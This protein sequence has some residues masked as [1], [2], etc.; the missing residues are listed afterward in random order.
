MPK[1]SKYCTFFHN[2]LC[3]VCKT[4][5]EQLKICGNCKTLAYCSKEHQKHDWK[6]HKDICKVISSTDNDFSDFPVKTYEDFQTIRYIRCTAWQN[7]LNR[8]LENFENQMWM[9]PR[10]CAVCYSKDVKIDCRNCISVLYCSSEHQS[11][12]EDMHR[13]Y[14]DLLKLSIDFDIYQILN[15]IKLKAVTICDIPDDIIT[16][17]NNLF[18]LMNLYI[19]NLLEHEVEDRIKTI[20]ICDYG[21]PAANILFCLEQSGLLNGR[22]L[23]KKT[24]TIHLVGA[25]IVEIS[26]DWTIVFDMLFHWIRNLESLNFTLVGPELD[27]SL[28]TKNVGNDMCLNCK[29]NKVK[30]TCTFYSKMYHEVVNDLDKPDL[31]VA[32]NSGL[33]A[34]DENSWGESI[35]LLTKN[36]EV[37]LLLTAYTSKELQ[38]DVDI[39][40]KNSSPNL[41][42]IVEPQRNPFSC[43]RPMRDFNTLNVPIFYVNGYIAIFTSTSAD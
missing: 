19:K 35:G 12:Y 41:K 14:C 42:L 24:L 25:D 11:I 30:V 34:Y 18:E 39:V 40:L 23:N 4:P 3:Q 29:E 28:S 5:S 21:S 37:P 9:F 43:M 31:V 10:V 36:P 33:H 2:N 27:A 16:L 20:K 26:W 13:H 22:N 1:L 17:P 6:L 32:F 7:R 38:C 8:P 15:E